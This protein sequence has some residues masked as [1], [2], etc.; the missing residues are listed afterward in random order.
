[1][2]RDLNAKLASGIG[3]W[4]DGARRYSGW[5]IAFCSAVTLVAAFYA[6]TELGVNSDNVQMV[7]EDLPSRRNHE[8]FARLFPNL[9]NALLVVIDA[10]TPELAREAATALEERLKADPDYVEDA[11]VPGGGRFFETHGLLYRSPD[12]LD[13]F[14]D[15]M[16]RMQPI[17]ATLEQ[18]PS[19]ASLAS[20]IEA[21][22]EG[23][24]QAEAPSVS[25]EDW[26]AILDSV[27][28]A[29]LAVYSEFPLALSWE[30]ILLQGSEVE[31]ARRRILVVHP[32]LDFESFLTAGTIMDRIRE[33]AA[34]LGLDPPHGVE[35]RITGNPAL[36]YEEVL[37]LA[38]DL[39][40]G[41][42]VCFLFVGGVIFRALRS[43][44]LV[45]AA[46]ATLV[47]GLIWSAATAAV[48]VG[49]LNLV[50]AA[51]GVLF[52]GLGVDFAI[53]LGMA[54]AA[55]IREGHEHDQAL[56]QASESVG[57]SLLICTLTTAIGFF[58]FAPTD[59]L[60]VA[61][62]GLI[63]GYGMFIIL[64][65]TLTLFPA[66]LS[67]W[68]RIKAPE[69]I[70]GELHFRSTWWR[71]SETHPGLVL[72]VAGAFF[73]GSLLLAPK[74]RFDLNVIEMR[75]A[76]T[77][78]VQTFNDLLAQS[79]PMSPW[80]VNS[81]A[82]DFESAK[83]LAQKM[84]G[85]P[86]VASTLTLT[87]YVP[88]D[89]A[90]KLEILTDLGYLMDAPPQ[91]PDPKDSRD[92]E[93]QIAALRDLHTFL[94]ASWIENDSGSEL[95]ASVRVLR[96]K[97][98][99][100]L[101]RIENDDDPRVALEKLDELLLSG[102]PDQVARLEMAINTNGIRLEELPEDLVSRMISSDG[103]IRVQTFPREDL[104]NEEAFVRF[105][106]EVQSVDPQAAGVAINLVGFGRAT[107]S[108]FEQALISAIVIITALLFA[109]WRRVGP[110][111]LVISP[112]A[113]SSLLTVAA[114]VLLGI[115]FN[116]GNIIVIPLL[117]GIGV[118]SGVHLVQRALQSG[119]R[120]GDLMDSTTARAVFYSAL[121]TTVSF[122]TLAFSSHRGMASLGV[123]L[124]IGMV[125]TVIGN[126][127][128]L[129]AL[130]SRFGPR[131]IADEV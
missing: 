51:F 117:L 83:A 87:D 26:A 38:W 47:V 28:N 131:P 11:Y 36:N 126:L 75:D 125:A 31:V 89:Q 48:V 15:Q 34:E 52:I 18:D 88:E 128:V 65:L 101:A 103:Q 110:V 54:Y 127:I 121:T 42:A 22:L 49:H 53:H 56:R 76:T 35:I 29:T 93:S 68:L 109:L 106:E 24:A 66:L 130:L 3:R 122:G 92:L 10:Q 107:R 111:L 2:K 23:T 33:Q 39:G 14:A 40:L 45:V 104:G 124:A 58:V 108:S 100:F 72:G 9:E 91:T 32:V 81:V 78:S 19:I 102:L 98:D 67:R 1:V 13:I 17:L 5:V 70:A 74:A 60:G 62:L 57:G 77:E 79:G 123:V 12:E 55:G 99:V 4:V 112:L 105:T 44:R 97:L 84:E 6:A 118:D 43:L 20:L 120:A 90:E 63:A 85:L 30:Q 27:G 96:D 94:G 61:E 46:L 115:P 64:F 37:G 8:A 86:S 71:F 82:P 80:F 50:S 114:M 16:A 41:G 69:E 7:A 59:Y 119:G 113:L 95:V 21:G 116:F 73:A 25:S 129:P